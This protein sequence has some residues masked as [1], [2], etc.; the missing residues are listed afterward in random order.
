MPQKQ[1]TIFVEA[2]APA[3]PALGTPCNGCGLCCLV[4]PC[5]LGILLSRRRRGACA[6]LRWESVS[7]TYQ[8]GAIVQPQQVLL[9]ALP[10][11]ARRLAPWLSRGL[12]RLAPRWIAAGKGCDSSLEPDGSTIR[13][14]GAP[15]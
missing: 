7:A 15:P 4:A 12:R 8:C 6:A 13:R 2:Q 11:M 10:P 3:K 1:W 5:P 9:A 14:C